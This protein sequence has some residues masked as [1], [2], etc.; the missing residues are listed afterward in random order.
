LDS[1]YGKASWFSK[2]ERREVRKN[3]G[4]KDYG[5]YT[6]RLSI[7]VR[8]KLVGQKLQRFEKSLKRVRD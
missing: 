8:S 3:G 7:R 6:G 1:G 2:E 5:G 4:R